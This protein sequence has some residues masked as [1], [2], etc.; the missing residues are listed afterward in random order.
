MRLLAALLLAAAPALAEPCDR[1]D[2]VTAC[3]AGPVERYG[4]DVLGDTP[5]WG[6][7]VMTLPDGTA[8]EAVLPETRIFED[9][10]P[11]LHDIGSDGSLEAIVV[12]TDLEAGAQLA[13]YALD[14]GRLVK[15]AATP[16]IGRRF[17]WLAPVGVGD[18]DGDGVIDIAVVE[19]P[20]LDGTLRVWT[21]APGGLTSVATARGFSNHRIGEA[22]ITSGLRVC[23]GEP[24]EMVL[25][26]L[27]WTR[28]I[29]V[30]LDGDRLTG[31]VLG[32]RPDRAALEAALAC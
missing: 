31:R 32:S 26:D 24:V 10:A 16:E 17:R 21:F 18:L 20:H 6:R 5:E 27:R 9:I 13:V 23:P 8:A 11:R 2:G 4:H 14:R 30:R 29:A 7:L 22:G 28:L 15:I 19:R 3:F 1:R 12:E 25:P